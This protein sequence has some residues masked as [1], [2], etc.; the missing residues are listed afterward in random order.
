MTI[1]HITRSESATTPG[2][3]FSANGNVLS[4]AGNSI[5]TDNAA[6]YLPLIDRLKRWLQAGAPPQ[7]TIEFRFNSLNTSSIKYVMM[8]L[9]HVEAAYDQTGTCLVR[10]IYPAHDA[11]MAEIGED[12]SEDLHLDIDLVPVSV[13]ELRASA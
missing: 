11:A 9:R 13:A 12:L 5:P 10:W 2:I 8:L 6:F 7:L 4:F 1:E 3:H